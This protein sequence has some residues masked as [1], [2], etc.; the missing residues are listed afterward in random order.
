MKFQIPS[1]KN[2][3]FQTTYEVRVD[4]INYGNHMGNERF[5]LAAQECRSRYFQSIGLSEHHIGEDT[6]IVVANALVQYKAEVFY[7]DQLKI[8]LG[9]SETGRSS[10]DFVYQIYRL[11]KLVATALTTV[12][13]VGIS[14]RKPKS[15]PEKLLIQ[16]QE[17]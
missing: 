6:G 1:A 14:T 4:D 5:L 3:L 2:E 13:C 8:T 16:I 9:V 7:G 12:V 10:I 15:I 11:D 17:S